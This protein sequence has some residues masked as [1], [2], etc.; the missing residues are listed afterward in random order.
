MNLWAVILNIW[1]DEPVFHVLEDPMKPRLIDY[2]G[3]Y[4]QCGRRVGSGKP[5]LPRKHAVKFAR[6][7]KSCSAQE[8]T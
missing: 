4:T 2:H 6:R 1:A 3:R 7:C 8:A 5:L